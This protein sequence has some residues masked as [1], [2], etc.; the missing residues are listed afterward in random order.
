MSKILK[1]LAD[2]CA[3]YQVNTDGYHNVPIGSNVLRVIKEE[4]I[5]AIGE[6]L[7]EII[8]ED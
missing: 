4:T 8:E 6:M 3:D 1:K 5:N 7:K 2:M